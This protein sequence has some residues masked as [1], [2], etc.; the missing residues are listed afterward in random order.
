MFD[1]QDLPYKLIAVILSMSVHEFAHALVS[2]LMGD[3]TAK[4]RGRLTLNPFAHIDWTGIL[5]LTFLGFGWGK[6]VPIDSGYYK[7]RKLGIVWTSFAG[8]LANFILTFVVLLIGFLMFRF[9]PGFTNTTVGIIIDNVIIRTAYMSAGLGVFNLLPVPPLDGSKIFLAFLPDETY[10]R[11]IQGNQYIYFIFIAL[12]MTGFISA[13]L[14]F[15]R[16]GYI[17]FVTDL[18]SK[19]LF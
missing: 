5:C 16:N 3:P 6:P 10:Y 14:V 15:L 19:L 7:D 9:I 2:Y 1:F 8:P 12:L 17:S 13:P 11:V 4:Q 18:L